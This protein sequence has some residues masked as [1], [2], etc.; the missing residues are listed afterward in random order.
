MRKTEV[1]PMEPDH[2]NDDHDD[3]L[4]LI[5]DTARSVTEHSWNEYSGSKIFELLI[6]NGPICGWITIFH[7]L[8]HDF[9]LVAR[10]INSFLS[11][12]DLFRS[13]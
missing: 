7:G 5:C 4:D 2:Q 6:V 12:L 10:L 3:D 13:T 8:I 11:L 9:A 1:I